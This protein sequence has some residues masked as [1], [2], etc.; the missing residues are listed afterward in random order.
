MQPRSLSVVVLLL[1]S[2]TAAGASLPGSGDAGTGSDAGDDPG[3]ATTL[4]GPGTYNGTLSPPGDADWYV[5]EQTPGTPVCFQATVEGAVHAD[6]V[7]SPTEGLAPAVRRPAKPAHVLDLGVTTPSSTQVYLGLAPPAN[8]SQAETSVGWYSFEIR[9]V[10]P[11]LPGAGD[12]GQEGDAGPD[13]SSAV[14]TEGPC[15][16]GSL[17]GGTDEADAYAFEADEGE[18]VALSLAQ[19]ASGPVRVSLVSPSGD[20]VAAVRDGGFADVELAETG[21]WLVRAELVGDATT[22][23]TDDDYLVGL[24]VNGPEPPPCNPGCVEHTG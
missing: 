22:K 12:G 3:N 8:P 2:V 11:G 6:G 21:E 1:V 19:A 13:R 5:L 4:S 7:L 24:T 9:A 14:E 10:T 20:E 16:A 17:S 23:T 18:H 15:V